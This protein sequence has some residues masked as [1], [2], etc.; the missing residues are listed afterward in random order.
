MQADGLN[1]FLGISL[2]AVLVVYAWNKL[3]KQFVLELDGRKVAYLFLVLIIGAGLI[4]NAGLKNQ[5][6]RARPRDVA[7][8]IARLVERDTKSGGRYVASQVA[9]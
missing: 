4:V 7:E 8:R 5:M 2:V 6:G 3:L 1:A 9:S